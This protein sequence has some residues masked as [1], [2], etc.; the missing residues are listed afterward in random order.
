MKSFAISRQISFVNLL[1]VAPFSVVIVNSGFLLGLY[2]F[3]KGRMLITYKQLDLN[4][5]LMAITL[6]LACSYLYTLDE[7]NYAKNLTLFPVIIWTSLSLGLFYMAIYC[8]SF[9]ITLSMLL[10]LKLQLASQVMVY[11]TYFEVSSLLL[12]VYLIA[13]TCL[14]FLHENRI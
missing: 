9:M 10:N 12:C 2:I 5:V 11:S 1:Y 6:G 7:F 13:V 14:I 3:L 8:A 4:K